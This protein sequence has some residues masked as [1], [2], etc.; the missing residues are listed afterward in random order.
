MPIHDDSLG[1]WSG[2]DLRVYGHDLHLSDNV[3]GGAC[4][5]ILIICV[6]QADALEL[7]ET[8]VAWLCAQKFK[9]QLESSCLLL[10]MPSFSRALILGPDYDLHCFSMTY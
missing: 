5:Y 9:F 1:Y 10:L 2:S 8:N 4:F 3:L 7:L 6:Q